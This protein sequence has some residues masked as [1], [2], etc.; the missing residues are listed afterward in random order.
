[1]KTL[2]RL[3]TVLIFVF[4]YAPIAIMI[5]FSFNSLESTTAFG[6]FSLD[7]YRKLFADGEVWVAVKNTM[8]LAGLSSV[9]ATV[10]GTAAAIGLDKMKSRAIRES[11]RTVTN[12]PMMNPDIVTGVSLFLLF[13][14]VAVIF[15]TGVD[16]VL[17]FPAVLIAHVT[18]NLP[19]VILSVAPKIRQQ[20]R[21]LTEAAL[22]LG[23]TPL[24]AF[25]KVEL[26][27]IMPGILS[28]FM[29][30]FTLSI[31][32]FVITY[33]LSGSEYSTLPVYIYG[34][35]GKGTVTPD[36]YA[37]STLLCLAVLGL[38]LLSNLTKARAERRKNKKFA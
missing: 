34:L 25:F 6:G 36:V 27:G 26:P 21:H 23:C 2:S 3:Y 18:F 1:M 28:G 7:W 4:L 10:V 22:D 30:A 24:S 15:G 31:D 33:F 17:G 35:T 20:D 11:V 32:D 14:M 9:I 37:L 13:A 29:M 38:L 12:I 8:I 16:A 19:Y 5:F